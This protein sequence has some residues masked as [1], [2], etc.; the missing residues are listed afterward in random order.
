MELKPIRTDDQA[1]GRAPS[2]EPAQEAV[3][4]SETRKVLRNHVT[5]CSR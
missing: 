2:Y 5:C 3:D 4:V 1:L